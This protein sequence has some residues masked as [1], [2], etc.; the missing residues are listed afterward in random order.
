MHFGCLV[1]AAGDLMFEGVV[2]AFFESVQN[3]KTVG[4]KLNYYK[5]VKIIFIAR[6]LPKQES[7]A[8]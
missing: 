8:N 3:H 7:T 4:G 1:T 6:I 2:T 5:L